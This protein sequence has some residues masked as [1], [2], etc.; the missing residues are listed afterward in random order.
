VLVVRLTV[1]HFVLLFFVRHQVCVSDVPAIANVLKDSANTISH[2][3]VR[4]YQLPSDSACRE[5]SIVHF[6]GWKKQYTAFTTRPPSADAHILLVTDNGF[7]PL[8]L[9]GGELPSFG[10]QYAA[11]DLRAGRLSPRTLK[12]GG[13][14]SVSRTTTESQSPLVSSYC[15][16]YADNLKSCL[17]FVPLDHITIAQRALRPVLPTDVTLIA[18]GWAED[19]TSGAMDGVL[20][21][22]DGPKVGLRIIRLLFD[23]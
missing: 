18:T 23:S 17:C 2:H 13:A 15:S 16:A 6:Q 5:A 12:K 9:T 19:F 14:E 20:E 11:R 3:T 4:S 10:E 8:R 21:G 1:L 22:W 7:I